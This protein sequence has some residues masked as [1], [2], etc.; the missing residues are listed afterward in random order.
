ML[1]N[2]VVLAAL[3]Q[4]G[5]TAFAM[6][7]IAW[8]SGQVQAQNTAEVLSAERT[9]TVEALRAD[10]AKVMAQI[11]T[12]LRRDHVER[13]AMAA[14]DVIDLIHPV[15]IDTSQEGIRR[16]GQA[17]NRLALLQ[18]VGSQELQEKL[19]AGLSHALDLMIRHEENT[20]AYAETVDQVTAIAGTLIRLQSRLVVPG[21]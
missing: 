3:I 7:F 16:T 4:S 21:S 1:D 12:Q 15:A 9:N 8:Q 17:L 14:G 19:S 10:R 11:N 20:E 5:I 2:P 13:F 6:A 18:H